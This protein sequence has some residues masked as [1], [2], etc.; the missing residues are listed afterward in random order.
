MNKP[1]NTDLFK[2]LAESMRECHSHPV[3][4]TMRAL[5]QTRSDIL[6]AEIR[7]SFGPG[8]D[9]E[10]RA[11]VLGGEPVDL[12]PAPEHRILGASA[13]A[14]TSGTDF[15]ATFMGAAVQAAP[16]L[17]LSTVIK[18]TSGNRRSYSF[19]VTQ[20]TS[21]AVTA[22]GAAITP[23]DPTFGT[24]AELDAYK[25]PNLILAS[26][27]LVTDSALSF[28]QLCADRVA[29]LAAR[30]MSDDLWA[31]NG[32]TAPQGLLAGLTTVTAAG[33]AV[34][35]FAD[36]ANLLRQVPTAY[37]DQGTCS[38]ILSPGALMDLVTESITKTSGLLTADRILNFPY[39]VDGALA[40]PASAAKSVVA[41]DFSQAYLTR[42]APLRI[43]SAT[44]ADI[45][46]RRQFRIVLRGDGKRMV[47]DA[48]RAL[49]HP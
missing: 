14:N 32:T 33:A 40:A 49:V 42:L 18:T 38:I 12:L 11:A 23:S 5:G 19:V 45:S 8:I 17:E 4:T 1:P 30:K 25:Y 35:A 39:R 48:C 6:R 44:S 3:G 36:V 16:L 15:T 26:E 41:G 20:L 31:G 28:E 24:T 22:P 29:P 37:R 2:R 43:E 34:V 46:E 7:S 27:E 10:F 21:N 9:A 13:I 47:T